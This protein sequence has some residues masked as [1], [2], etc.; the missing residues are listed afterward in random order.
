VNQLSADVR[1]S[2]FEGLS[3]SSHR[4]LER[5]SGLMVAWPMR[6]TRE[7]TA[8]LYTEIRRVLA[9]FD[10]EDLPVVVNIDFGHTSQMVV[11][12][13]CR[14]MIDPAA[15]RVAVLE[16][17]V[18][19]FIRLSGSSF[20]TSRSVTAQRET[21]QRAGP[22]SRGGSHKSLRATPQQSFLNSLTLSNHLLTVY[23]VARSSNPARSSSESSVFGILPLAALKTRIWPKSGRANAE[24]PWNDATPTIVP[25][26]AP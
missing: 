15:K 5:I 20:A 21:R 26:G 9:E 3:R 16:S 24:C 6:Y 11:P 10:R 14:A 17:P 7:M 18:A 22:H 23:K 25:T 13:G 2:S 19:N 8:A 4:I 1:Q 12:M